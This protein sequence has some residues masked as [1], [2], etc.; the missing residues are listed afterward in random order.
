MA[1]GTPSCVRPGCFLNRLP[2]KWKGEVRQAGTPQPPSGSH[3]V[4]E[5]PPKSPAPAFLLRPKVEQNSKV[6]MKASDLSRMSSLRYRPGVSLLTAPACF[7]PELRRS[8]RI[9]SFHSHPATLFSIRFHVRSH[10]CQF[11]I[12]TFTVHLE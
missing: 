11:C 10:L 1:A 12:S 8:P 6:E 3:P 5:H 4:A 2:R 7:F 9:L